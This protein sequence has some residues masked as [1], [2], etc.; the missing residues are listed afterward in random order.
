MRNPV[1]PVLRTLLFLP[2]VCVSIHSSLHTSL[3]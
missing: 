1:R 3:C 2:E